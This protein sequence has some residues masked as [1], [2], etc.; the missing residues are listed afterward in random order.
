MPDTAYFVI[1]DI[2]G[3]TL[4]LTSSELEHAQLIL[5][6]LLQSLVDA[7]RPPLGIS[8]FEGDAI[9]AYAP[10]GDGKGVR[11]EAMLEAV[12]TLYCA[13]AAVRERMQLNAYCPCNACQNIKSLDLKF[14]L[15]RGQY[16]L[17]N[18]GGRQGLSGPDVIATHRLLK[19]QVTAKTGIAAYALITEPAARAIALPEF[20]AGLP[21]VSENYEH[22]GTVGGFV[23]DLGPVWK[24]HHESTRVKLGPN[25]D[26]F[27]PAVEVTLPVSLARAW[28][29][30]ADPAEKARWLEGSVGVSARD[31]QRGRTAIGS[32]HS[33]DH[34]KQQLSLRIVDWRPFDYVTHAIDLPL[35]VVNT[36]TLTV[37]EHDSGSKI[38]LYCRL[39]LPR[40]G[41]KRLIAEMMTAG[42][43]GSFARTNAK[44]AEN[45]QRIAAEDAE[46]GRG[47]APMAAEFQAAE[48]AAAAKLAATQP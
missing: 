10:D 25:D 21:Q 24:Q 29:Y 43:R 1:A 16:V 39:E 31:L 8:N 4:F 27:V 22:V 12:E 18:V 45:L 38:G 35:G 6:E 11:G 40:G 42:L 5:T 19:N 47:A 32:T 20:F 36:L 3:Y 34:G 28:D 46:A 30:L 13:F 9:L 33:C 48:I 37:A 14:I 23:H 44:N 17:Q 26:L 15:H 7:S 2:T 41:V